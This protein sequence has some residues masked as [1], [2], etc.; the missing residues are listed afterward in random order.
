MLQAATLAGQHAISSRASL[1]GATDTEQQGD[2]AAAEGRW[3]PLGCTRAAKGRAGSG[4]AGLFPDAQSHIV[5]LL[6]SSVQRNRAL[7]QCRA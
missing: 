1:P 2:W 4:Q 6:G 5:F 7:C 3:Q